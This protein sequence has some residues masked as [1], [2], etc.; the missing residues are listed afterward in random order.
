MRCSSS[1]SPTFLQCMPLNVPLFP[2][3]TLHLPTLGFK[4]HFFTWRQRKVRLFFSFT[5]ATQNIIYQRC[6]NSSD[7]HWPAK[8]KR[9]TCFRAKNPIFGCYNK[10]LCSHQPFI[11]IEK[12]RKEKQVWR[13]L[14]SPLGLTRRRLPAHCSLPFCLINSNAILLPKNVII[15]QL[16]YHLS[17]SHTHMLLLSFYFYGSA[18]NKGARFPVGVQSLLS[19]ISAIPYR[20]V[21]W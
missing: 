21:P 11:Q 19:P 20:L 4:L 9:T 13:R 1:E 15:C 16:L 3:N 12:S 8:I 18:L 5:R 14:I 2:W 7:S 10:W 6:L 17:Y